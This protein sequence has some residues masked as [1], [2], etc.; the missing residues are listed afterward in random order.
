MFWPDSLLQL[1]LGTSLHVAS[2]HH[3]A[4]ALREDFEQVRI[5]LHAA[6]AASLALLQDLEFSV[7]FH[8]LTLLA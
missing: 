3:D 6:A 2:V 1:L 8:R 4:R 5:S 7:I